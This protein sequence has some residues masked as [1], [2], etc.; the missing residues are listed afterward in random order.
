MSSLLCSLPGLGWGGVSDFQLLHLACCTVFNC[1]SQ[2]T[3]FL[4]PFLLDLSGDIPQTEVHSF[5]NLSP[6]FCFSLDV[7]LLMDGANVVASLFLVVI[8]VRFWSLMCNVCRVH[9]LRHKLDFISDVGQDITICII[10]NC[11]LT[12]TAGNKNYFILNLVPPIGFVVYLHQ[13]IR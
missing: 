3:A 11:F 9:R 6:P 12:V 10:Y 4:F 8:S 1:Y 13:A 5:L 7:L 2:V